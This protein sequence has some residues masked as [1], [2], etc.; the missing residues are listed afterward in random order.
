LRQDKG[1]KDEYQH[2]YNVLKGK[3]ENVSIKD[4]FE[5]HDKLL[6]SLNER[7]DGGLV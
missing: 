2:I 3:E 7:L 5:S 4:A 1:I 6:K